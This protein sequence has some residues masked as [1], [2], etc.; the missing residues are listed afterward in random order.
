M[1]DF[2]LNLLGLEITS[3]H[4]CIQVHVLIFSCLIVLPSSYLECLH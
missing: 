1:K 2:A 4:Q 3:H